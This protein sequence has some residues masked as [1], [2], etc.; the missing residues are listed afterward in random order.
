M[1]SKKLRGRLAKAGLRRHI[2]DT[3]ATQLLACEKT[4]H[5]TPDWELTGNGDLRMD[6]DVANSMS[7]H[8][9]IGGRVS[10]KYAGKS[11]WWLLWGD[12]EQG[13]CQEQLRRLDIRGSHSNP[14][15]ER[16]ERK[17]HKHLWSAEHKNDHAYTPDDIP[18]DQPGTLVTRDNYREIFEAFAAECGIKTGS[19]Y[20]WSEPIFKQQAGQK[21]IWEVQ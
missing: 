14:D 13:E 17:T 20:A 12:N 5:S 1:G 4:I 9:Q 16:W 2:T 21:S 19:D 15:D 3:E 11:T 18:H 6:M 8:L 7:E 10:A